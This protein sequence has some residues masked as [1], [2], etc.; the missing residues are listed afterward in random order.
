MKKRLIVKRCLELLILL[1]V[2]S[3]GFSEGNAATY[4]ATGRWNYS[5]TGNWADPGCPPRDNETGTVTVIQTGNSVEIVADDITFYGSVSGAT[6]TLSASNAD[7]GGTT[8][9]YV[10]F[11]LSSSS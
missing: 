5:I 4:E 7:P 6:Y 8:T 9:Q 10:K 1:G 3:I 2:I 11:T